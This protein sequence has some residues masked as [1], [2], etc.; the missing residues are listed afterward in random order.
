MG[1]LRVLV[2]DDQPILSRLVCD[3]LR[4]DFH[5]TEAAVSASEALEKFPTGR[6]DLVIT[7]H[8]MAGMTG[9]QLAVKIKEQDPQVPVI[10]LTGYVIEST[11]EKH[12]S[13]AI[14]LVLGKPLSRAS[15]RHAL[16][17]VLT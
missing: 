9:E 17:K 2:V 1:S 10:L 14:D 16:A 13:Q 15:L 11:D 6:F 7:D 3:F 12:Y 8:V 4:E 5:T